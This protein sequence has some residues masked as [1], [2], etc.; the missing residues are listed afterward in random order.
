MGGQTTNKYLHEGWCEPTRLFFSA[1]TRRGPW[2]GLTTV[3]WPMAV[4]SPSGR[5]G[6]TDGMAEAPSRRRWFYPT[7]GRFVAI[8]LAVEGILW[9]AE[10]F[11]WLPK[12]YA[13]LIA[14]ASVGLFV[15]LAVLWLGVA[16]LFHLRF[17]F[18]LRSLLMLTVVV[19]VSCSWLTV[20]MKKAREQTAAVATILKLEGRP[21]YDWQVDASG[22]YLLP[23]AQ[24][25]VP[26]WLR[27]LLE[28]D[29]FSDVI[30]A[31]CLKGD[32]TDTDL[33]H[34]GKLTRLTA[35]MIISP[36]VTDAGVEHLRGLTRLGWLNLLCGQITDVGLEHLKGLTRLRS[37]GLSGSR[38]TDAG[39]EHLTG[40]GRLQQ[41]DLDGTRVTDEGLRHLSGLAHLRELSLNSTKITD[42]GLTHIKGLLEL[43]ALCLFDDRIS[44]AG[45]EHLVGLPKLR[46]LLLSRATVTDAGL[47]HIK[48]LKHLEVLFLCGTQ[49]TDAGLDK[50]AA[51]PQLSY[52]DLADTPITDVGLAHLSKLKHLE[53]LRLPGTRITDA[54]LERLAGLKTLTSLEVRNTKVTKAGAKK[55]KQA[56]PNCNI[57]D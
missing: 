48:A 10:Q 55:L 5:L 41:L 42:A 46:Q 40:F 11:R 34:M 15:L 1:L 35:M 54:G 29:F 25:P 6:Y 56:L 20:E 33:E 18:S 7:P 3:A 9:L 37:L 38:V 52:L 24:S 36:H 30:Q 17:Q 27:N 8:L 45:L 47:R 22:I 51:M 2:R 21:A 53:T 12:G 57:Y 32:T 44:D 50:L 43:D 14:V 19:A 4:F 31:G 28:E 13:V 39:L 26:G 16:L 23:N 49:I